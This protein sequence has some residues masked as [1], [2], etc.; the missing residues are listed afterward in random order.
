M[1]K[2]S[3]SDVLNKNSSKTSKIKNELIEESEDKNYMFK[4]LK[5]NLKNFNSKPCFIIKFLLTNII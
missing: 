4:K 3:S 2:N 5:N 1:I